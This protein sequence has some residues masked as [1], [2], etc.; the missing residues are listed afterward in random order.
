MAEEMKELKEIVL[1]NIVASRASSS[2]TPKRFNW[3]LKTE[4]ELEN[5]E[6]SLQAPSCFETEVL[7]YKNCYPYY[8]IV[9]NLNY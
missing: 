6:D 1:R 4:E 7:H 5:I 2:L 9:N 3:P 8:S